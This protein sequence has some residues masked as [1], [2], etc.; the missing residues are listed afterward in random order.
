MYAPK[1][2]ENNSAN[3]DAGYSEIRGNPHQTA[4]PRV[5][6]RS[7]M[8]H[9]TINNSNF[10]AADDDHGEEAGFDD[11][12]HSEEEREEEREGVGERSAEK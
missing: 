11:V 2:R 9:T 4:V 5:I 3:S 12:L 8:E 10:H 7:K 1:W 6:N